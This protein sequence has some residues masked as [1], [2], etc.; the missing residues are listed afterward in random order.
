MR[1][2]TPAEGI[3]ALEAIVASGAPQMGVVPFNVRQW[4]DVHPTA[5]ASKRLAK[6][7]TSEGAGA[8]RAMGDPKLLALLAVASPD[9]RVTLLEAFLRTQASQVLR[10]PEAKLDVDVPLTSIGLDSLMGLELRNRI[11]AGL[12]VRVP[13]TLLWT[14][15]T[16]ALLSRNVTLDGADAGRPKPPPPV[17]HAPEAP[18]PE[19][20][21]ASEMTDDE[22]AALIV[23]RFETVED[24]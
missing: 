19:E 8:P 1:S 24:P 6:L 13:A 23:S 9:E 10:I 20:G 3:A 15:P 12:G 7:L 18:A 4:I 22:L 14:F 16:I 2:L 11:E 21:D 5:A 17:A